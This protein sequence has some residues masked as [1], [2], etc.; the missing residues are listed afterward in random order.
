MGSECTP[1]TNDAR[2]KPQRIYN[3]AVGELVAIGAAIAANCEPCFKYHVEQAI[4]LGVSHDDMACA[5]TMARKVKEAP[6]RAVLNL[7][8]KVLGCTASAEE[9]GAPPANTCCGS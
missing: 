4:K 3:L 1:D 6:A 5:V 9:A 8:N 7:A 2:Q